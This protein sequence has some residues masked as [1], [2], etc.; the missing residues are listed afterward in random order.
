MANDDSNN[1]NYDSVILELQ[2]IEELQETQ[3]KLEKKISET[4]EE[5]D[6][7]KSFTEKIEEAIGIDESDKKKNVIDGGKLSSTLTTSE[8]KRYENIGKEFV[9]GAGKELENVRKAVQFK[10]AMSTV[11]NK[12]AEGVVKFK[13]G[14]KKARKSGS[15]FG[16]LMVIIGLLGTIV[17]LFKD[18]ILSAFPN[19]GEHI[20]NIFDT[21][22]GVLGN[23]L[24]SVI[25]Y[26]T[27]GIGS[28][29]MNLLKEVVVNVIPNFIGTFFQFTLPNAIVTLYL[30]ILSSFSGDAS[31][32]YDKRVGEM[33]EE[34]MDQLGEAASQELKQQ[35]GVSTTE[36]KGLIDA[37]AE[38]QGR[39]NA[40]G[41][42]AEY[43]ELRQAQLGA[44][45]LAITGDKDSA[46]VLAHLDQ[47]VSGN[48]DFK[49]L[50]DSGQFNTSTF[51]S[52]IQRAK[53]DGLT[54][55]EI[56]E[57]ML[58]SVT[59]EMRDS[60]FTMA[61]G[62]N[63]GEVSNF[64][65]ALIRM[66]DTSQATQN[67]ISGYMNEKRQA[68]QEEQDRL[69]EY[70]RTITEINATGVIG[71]ALAEAFKQLVENIVNF[72]NGNEIANSIEDSFKTMNDNF[73]EFFTEFNT[74]VSEAFS[75]LGSNIEGLLK[76]WRDSVVGLDQRVK[77]LE[78]VSAPKLEGA[79]ITQSYNINFNAIVNVD[80]SQQNVET[81]V[82]EL[83]QKVVSIDESLVN[84]MKSSNKTMAKVIESFGNVRD[85]H[86]CSKT[87]VEDE[88]EKRC[89]P[90]DQ[91]VSINAIDI[92]NNKEKIASIENIIKKPVRQPIAT[93]STAPCLDVS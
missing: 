1:M 92:K 12:F 84:A 89:N 82:S 18:K 19:I 83:V 87:Y 22:K 71:E 34:D 70:K 47:I 42:N 20:T 35:A 69:K 5:V 52:E 79:E 54:Q 90:L 43:T 93:G 7:M 49:K 24:G 14:L 29:F 17:Y 60:G 15:F 39:V 62:V 64:S 72:L 37:T 33:L 41:A 30:G 25:D 68:Q 44:S 63:G 40:L 21:A 13:E 48:Q 66:S 36:V 6:E 73:K 75:N 3:E 80:L 59:Q 81:S 2:R 56:Y 58:K 27:Q 32:M 50:I 77:N 65:N 67:Q 57:A 53:S 38:A 85:L 74:F 28:T 86:T 26:V 9:A 55:D 61:E 8:K 88:I 11:R 76:I 45:A 31:K 23:M 10:D 46:A 51:L 91:N 4:V 78:A 16:K